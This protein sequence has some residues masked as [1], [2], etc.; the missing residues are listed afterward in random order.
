MEPPFKTSMTPVP[1][2]KEL[3]KSIIPPFATIF[4]LFTTISPDCPIYAADELLTLSTSKLPLFVNVAACSTKDDSSEIDIIPL[5]IA[6]FVNAI[7][8]LLIPATLIVP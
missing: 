3:P 1:D 4:P 8:I 6:L 5:L 7:V 2:T